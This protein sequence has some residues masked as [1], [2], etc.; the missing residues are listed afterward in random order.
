[1]TKNSTLQSI[2]DNVSHAAKSGVIHLKTNATEKSTYLFIDNKKVINFSSY[3]YLGL[4]RNDKLIEGCIAATKSYGTQ[5]GFSRTY[6]AVDLYQKLEEELTKIFDNN[7]IVAPSTTLAHQSALPIIIGDNDLVIID[8]FAHASIYEAVKIIKEKGVT[9]QILRH[10][11]IDELEKR[12][13]K[14]QGKYPKIWYLCDGVYS[15]HGNF[16]PLKK[17]EQLMNNYCYFSVYIDD[18]HGMSWSGKKGEG[19]V[20]KNMKLH[21][22]MVIVTSLNKSF[23][24]SGGAIIV[25]SIELK[26]QIRN[27]GSTMI[28]STPI[29]PPMLGAGIASCLLH[30]TEE[31]AILQNKLR[32]NITHCIAKIKKLELL[33][34]SQ[35]NSPVFFIPCCFPKVC[36][37]LSKRML[38][39]GYYLTP[40]AY[41]AVSARKA[42]IR[43]C[44]SAD[45]TLKQIN[46]M[47]EELAKNYKIVLFEEG[48]NLSIISKYFKID[49]KTINNPKSKKKTDVVIEKFNSIKD[50]D[51]K[52]WN[53]LFNSGTLDYNSLKMFEDIFSG[54]IKREDNWDFHYFIIRDQKNNIVLATYFTECI[55]KEDLFKDSKISQRIEIKR[56]NDTYFMCS[57]CLLMGT[58]ITEGKHFF[59]DEN[60]PDWKQGL[61]LFFDSIN[62]LQFKN[63]INSIYLRDFDN[64]SVRLSDVFIENGYIQTELPCFSHVLNIRTGILVKEFLLELPKS[65]RRKIVYEAKRF[66]NKYNVKIKSQIELS[67][68]EQGYNLYLNVQKKSLTINSFPLPFSFFEAVNNNNNWEFIL[69]YLSDTEYVKNEQGDLVGIVLCHKINK[70][71]T[72][73]YM[74]IEYKYKYTHNIYKQV[75]WQIVKRSIE[76]NMNLVNLGLTASLHKTRYGANAIQKK[77][78]VQIM[79]TLNQE[80]LAIES[81]VLELV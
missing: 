50:I 30:Q 49:V 59:L 56:K 53:Y 19:Y 47:L 33:E 14:F 67:E 15:M 29:Q 24:A 34:I 21:K 75:L 17:I 20:L 54:N 4:E 73:L 22:Q 27:C 16:A 28:F 48:V 71:Y 2:S 45:H 80:V 11:A 46:E 42:G 63:G 1:M 76:A 3:S 52:E 78:F 26:Q 72:P 40:T 31:L 68:L 79:D 51:S 41:P 10:N 38:L 12:I 60:H 37:N 25:P 36:Y 39:A 5:F 44:I 74:G 58:P 61:L 23:A 69:L 43:F 13:I 70:V 81:A 62:K 8:Q 77:V 9:V 64:L 18:A 35:S 65:K 7:V 66:E 32:R 6:I 55:L 57:S